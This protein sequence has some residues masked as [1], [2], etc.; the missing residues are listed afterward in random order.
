MPKCFNSVLRGYHGSGAVAIVAS[1]AS[2]MVELG[3]TIACRPCASD[4]THKRCVRTSPACTLGDLSP[5][6]DNTVLLATTTERGVGIENSPGRCDEK[7]AQDASGPI[8][9]RRAATWVSP[10]SSRHM[11]NASFVRPRGSNMFDAPKTL[12]TLPSLWTYRTRPQ[13]TAK[14]AVFHCANSESAAGTAEFAGSHRRPR[15]PRRKG[16]WK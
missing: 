7:T 8:F 12:L 11:V 5:T 15:S 4:A 9:S 3:T 2:C 10:F 16:L 6:T 1:R 13:G 14:N